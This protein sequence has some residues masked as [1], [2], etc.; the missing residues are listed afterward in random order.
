M[1]NLLSRENFYLLRKVYLIW[2]QTHPSSW[3]DSFGPGSPSQIKL[4][5]SFSSLG[6][7]QVMTESKS[8]LS[9]R[10]VSCETVGLCDGG[11]RG[12]RRQWP[13]RRARVR[14]AS[15]TGSSRVTQALY[16][17]RVQ[18]AVYAVRVSCQH[19]RSHVHR[20]AEGAGRQLCALGEHFAEAE[21]SQDGSVES[22]EDVLGFEVSVNDI[23]SLRSYCSGRALADPS[24]SL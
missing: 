23:Y 16:A 3:S 11:R 6:S 7:V 4:R 14:R 5:V 2:H 15:R 1:S 18:V 19:L 12:V 13:R 17:Q 24:P 10:S 22:Q 21:V 9:L 20:R 8:P